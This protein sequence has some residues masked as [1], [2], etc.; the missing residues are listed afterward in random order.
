MATLHY[1][2]L[3]ELVVVAAT[4]HFLLFFSQKHGLRMLV[5]R[6]SAYSVS[7]YMFELGRVRSGNVHQWAI[8]FQNT[9]FHEAIKLQIC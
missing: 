2:I 8:C 4:K 6:I 3:G 7:T 9:I 1:E 5:A